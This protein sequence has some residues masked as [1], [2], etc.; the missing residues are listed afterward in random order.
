MPVPDIPGTKVPEGQQLMFL[1]DHVRELCR[2]NSTKYVSQAESL[3]GKIP[4][5]STRVVQQAVVGPPFEG[6]VRVDGLTTQFLGVR[7]IRWSACASV[8]RRPPR[9]WPTRGLFD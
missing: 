2:L 7:E 1:R 4:W 6:R 3:T 5:S 8:D 9:Y